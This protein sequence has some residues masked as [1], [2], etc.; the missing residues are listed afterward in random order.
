MKR[1]ELKIIG[2]RINSTRK[3]IARAIEAGDAAYIQEEARLQHEAGADF[4]DVNA[5]IFI[6]KEFEYLPWLVRTVQAAL[7]IPLSLDTPN[8]DALEAAL[9]EHCG[10]ALINSITLENERFERMAPLAR[11]YSAKV[12]ALTVDPTGIATEAKKKCEVAVRLVEAL[13]REGIKNEDIYLD[14]VVQ[15]VCT[16]SRAGLE[17]FAAMV[18][19]RR[20][21]PDVHLLCGLRNVSFHLPQR[22]L[23]DRTYLAMAMAAGIDTAILDPCDSAIM[24]AVAAAEVLLGKDDYCLRYIQAFRDGRLGPTKK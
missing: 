15:P 16:E 11:E 23:L 21:M 6:E 22:P 13:N 19:I 18:D 12:I 5:G 14:P 9:K 7:Q 20:L 3:S 24:A 2:E 1:C 8:P 4:I 17:T 10:R